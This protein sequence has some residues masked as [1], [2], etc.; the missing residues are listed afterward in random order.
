MSFY[1]IAL[2]SSIEKRLFKQKNEFCVFISHKKED[3]L[4]AID[5]GRYLME[6]VGVHIYLDIMDEK[7]QKATQIENDKVIVESIKEGLEYS[8]HLLCL[9]SEKTHLSWWVPYEIGVADDK[10]L[11][12][13]SLKLKKTDDIPSYLKIHPAFY[14]VDQFVRYTTN[15]TH[16]G[17]LFFESAYQKISKNTDI[18]KRHIDY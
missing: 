5:I 4:A 12:I 8:T 15:Y 3:K 17:Q 13:A 16:Y 6:T 9:I 14:N 7:L 18:L 10:N 2:E 1:N 11:N